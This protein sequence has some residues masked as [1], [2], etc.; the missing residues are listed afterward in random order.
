[1]AAFEQV[2][3]Q[4]PDWPHQLVIVGKKGWGEESKTDRS[5]PKIIFTGYVAD[6]DLPSLF[7]GAS[8][9]AYP[10]LYEGF[11]LPIIEAMACG[12]AVITSSYGAMREV[13]GNAAELIDPLSTD[14]IARGLEKVLGSPA[15]NRILQEQGKIHA[16]QFTTNKQASATLA[17]YEKALAQ[18]R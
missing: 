4:H 6:E 15:T 18:P 10:S 14:D 11:G 8:V 13:A 3:N 12:A 9:F 7:A 17:V 5:D 1:M 2:K 16:S